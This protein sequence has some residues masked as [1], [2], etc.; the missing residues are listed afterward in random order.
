MKSGLNIAY[1]P[2]KIA[3]EASS[4]SDCMT[5]VIYKKKKQEESVSE[6]EPETGVSTG[7]LE[8]IEQ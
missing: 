1:K 8:L 4:S 2:S 6:V 3:V 5:T 7:T